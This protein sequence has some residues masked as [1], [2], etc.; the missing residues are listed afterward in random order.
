M[1]HLLTAIATTILC[2]AISCG[3]E[4][5]LTPAAAQDGDGDG[6][7]AGGAG[8]GGAASTCDCPVP[9]PI[10]FS[11]HDAPCVDYDDTQAVA[12][13]LEGVGWGAFPLLRAA[14]VDP[15]GRL[16]GLPVWIDHVGDAWATCPPEGGL[17]RFWI[18]SP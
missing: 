16:T 7:G 18:P 4:V 2:L 8:A 13:T 14:H 3:A 10:R 5:R 12:A 15:T 11:T 1:R 17:V 9:E 6:A